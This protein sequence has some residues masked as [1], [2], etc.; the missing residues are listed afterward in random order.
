MFILLGHFPKAVQAQ[1]KAI[2][3]ASRLFGFGTDLRNPL[4]FNALGRCTGHSGLQS[5]GCFQGKSR[6]RPKPG[7]LPGQTCPGSGPLPRPRPL[8]G[9]LPGPGTLPGGRFQGQGCFHGEGGFQGRAAATARP[10][11]MDRSASR[12]QAAAGPKPL[13][14]S[15]FHCPRLLF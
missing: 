2:F 8:P 15:T 1:V 11:A 10:V 7:P 14:D 3:E 4:P 5:Q 9:S 6:A 12:E 13:S